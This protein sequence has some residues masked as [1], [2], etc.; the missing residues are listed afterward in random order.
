MTHSPF[1]GW[2][3]QQRSSTRLAFVLQTGSRV[4]GAVTGLLWT[5]LLLG[6][7]GD[8]LFGYFL[9]YQTVVTLGGLGDLGMG[10]AIGLKTG[11]D[12]GRGDER[13]LRDFLAG[14]RAVFLL[15][16]L[17]AGLGLLAAAPWLP[18]WLSFTATNGAGS[19]PMLFVVGAAIVALTP[20]LSYAGNLSHACGN[21]M[22]PV[23]PTFLLLQLTMAGH[24]LLARAGCALWVQALPYLVT[25]LATL[26]LTW[27]Y[28]RWSHPRLAEFLPLRLDRRL[29]R[30]L[31]EKSFWVYLCALGSMVFVTTDRLLISAGFGPAAL[32]R[33]QLNYKFCELALTVI[34]LAGFVSM[35]KITQW[36]ASP[37][38]EDRARAIK[39]AL[40]LSRFQTLLGV[41]IALA[42]LLVN[43]VFMRLWLGEAKSEL[44]R[45]PVAWQMAFAGTLVVTAG[46]DATVQL[47]GRIAGDGLRRAGTA[48][49][50]T[51]LLN[52]GLSYCAM[53]AGSITGIA[54]ATI[55]AQTGLSLA[56]CR[57]VC[58]RFGLSWWPWAWRSCILPLLAVALAG[59]A[60]LR[61]PPDSWGNATLLAGIYAVILAVIVRGSGFDL[62]FLRDEWR[63]LCGIFR[64]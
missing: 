50:L 4:F 40:R 8:T 63:L 38:A 18:D 57:F 26:A 6:A 39:E 52:L 53:K 54:V 12:L 45:A 25:G 10:G 14:A 64:R 21:L 5:R 48:I 19:F 16:A 2:L 17:T 23:L 44:L 1:I 58:G 61:W 37:A 41:A 55:I 28:V 46:A 20:L 47:S 62:A 22:W 3:K 56:L 7:M 9:A 27:L 34:I 24:W 49:G 11:Q 15:L 36:L 29:V 13:G 59:A 60:R 51:G 42:Y 30:D 35:P 43:D 31:L 32:P 33:Y